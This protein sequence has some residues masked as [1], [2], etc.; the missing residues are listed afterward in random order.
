MRLSKNWTWRPRKDPLPCFKVLLELY[1]LFTQVIHRVDVSILLIWYIL[2]LRM[3]QN[4]AFFWGSCIHQWQINC[5]QFPGLWIRID[6][7]RIRIQHFSSIRFRIRIQLRIQAKTELSMTISFSNFF[8]I[9]IWVKS[10]KK[11]PG[12]I[13]QIFFLS[14]SSKCYFIPF[15]W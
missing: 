14:K 6:S 9:K 2:N 13:H 7:M 4:H 15:W 10:N 11:I 8:E 1:F 12:V 3:F 5:S